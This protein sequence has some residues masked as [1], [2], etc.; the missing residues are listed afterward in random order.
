MMSMESIDAYTSCSVRL[1]L[2]V[3]LAADSEA[4]L[5][6]VAAAATAAV[7]P[8]PASNLPTLSRAPSNN[9]C[10]A[11]S[12][13]PTV[14]NFSLASLI[15]CKVVARLV[16]DWVSIALV[17]DAGLVRESR[18]RAR[19][20]MVAVVV[21]RVVVV[22]RRR[23]RAVARASMRSWDSVTIVLALLLLLV[24][25]LRSVGVGVVAGAD[26][27]GV[28]AATAAMVAST[29]RCYVLRVCVKIRHEFVLVPRRVCFRR[30]LLLSDVKRLRG[31]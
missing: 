6:P 26:V 9:L 4:A 17:S 29:G 11:G 7:A 22:V 25:L 31:T 12:Q 3:L 2:A 5:W 20:V 14:S 16:A 27:A 30:P 13:S 21:M 1:P 8:P 28:A 15:L 23:W 24:M 10:M 19:R 18:W